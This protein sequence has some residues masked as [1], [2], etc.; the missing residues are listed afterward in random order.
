M[1]IHPQVFN[2]AYS[3]QK[4]AESGNTCS[5]L[6]AKPSCKSEL[7]G[8][9]AGLTRADLSDACISTFHSKYKPTADCWLW[10]AGK[11]ASGYGMVF[12]RRENGKQVNSYAHRVA[13][14]LAKGPI[15]SGMVVRHRCDTPACVNPEHLQLG[16]QG[17]NNRDTASRRRCPKVRPWLHKLSDGDVQ[18]IRV[19]LA[20]GDA[21][22]KCY[23]VSKT[24]ISL[25]RRGLRRAA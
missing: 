21:L 13:Y 14:V 10:D 23:G 15:P 1:K 25:I 17:D 2:R 19:S 5:S 22:A 12:L 6:L 8:R 9:Y 20:S 11:Y 18:A 4:Q 24:S 16:T 7:V 3:L